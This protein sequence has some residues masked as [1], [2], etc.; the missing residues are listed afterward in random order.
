LRH[1]YQPLFSDRLDIAEFKSL[2]DYGLLMAALS[3]ET[4]QQWVNSEFASHLG[5]YRHYFTPVSTERDEDGDFLAAFGDFD[6]FQEYAL[7]WLRFLN[8]VMQRHY[9]LLLLCM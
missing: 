5:D 3:P 2:R 1:L 7:E 4:L 6:E 9:G 8:D